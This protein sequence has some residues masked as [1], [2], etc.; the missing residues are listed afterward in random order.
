MQ[1]QVKYIIAQVGVEPTS[2]GHAPSK[3]SLL[4]RAMTYAR[5]E[6]SEYCLERAASW[7]LLQY[8]INLL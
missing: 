7:P 6:P 5:F 3:L 4:Y 8:A 2:L 1:Y